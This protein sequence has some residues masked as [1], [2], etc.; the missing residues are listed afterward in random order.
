MGKY[1]LTFLGT[2]TSQGVPVI[3]CKCDVC[4]S[5][6]PNDTRLRS[7]V[8]VRTEHTSVV[9]DTGPDF[10]QQMLNARVERLDA[11]VFTHAHKDHIAGLDDVRA[12]NFLQRMDI[13]LYGD[14]LVEKAIKRDFY[15]AFEEEKYPGVPQLEFHRITKDDVVEVGDIQLNPVEVLHYKL[16][17]LGYRIGDLT[18]ITD[19][20]AIKPEELEKVRGSKI[21]ILNA[22]RKE[23]HLSHFT[24]DEAVKLAED[25]Q[26]EQAY[27]MHISHLM[28]KHADVQPE[29]PAHMSLAYDGLEIEF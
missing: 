28:G 29:L 19:A 8:W 13:P 27:F 23:S 18:Y 17:V 21:L 20:N 4:K 15:Y 16:P 7:A 9:I 22:L 11:V 5:K 1:T 25:L 12:F 3:G 24:L 26:V 2:G 6:D 10:R 14:A